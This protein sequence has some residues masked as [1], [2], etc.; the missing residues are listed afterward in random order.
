MIWSKWREKW[1]HYLVGPLPPPTTGQGPHSGQGQQPKPP[2]LTVPPPADSSGPAAP[3]LIEALPPPADS[4]GPAAPTLIEAA[5]LPADS[6]SEPT[7]IEAP[8]PGNGGSGGSGGKKPKHAGGHG[9]VPGRG[10]TPKA[11]F[12]KPS[13]DAV[14]IT[15]MAEAKMSLCIIVDNDL[16]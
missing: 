11:W 5:P 7:L 12:D 3:T 10:S 2:S 14:R 8:P 9:V 13:A 15:V 4:S 6:A 16:R 1:G